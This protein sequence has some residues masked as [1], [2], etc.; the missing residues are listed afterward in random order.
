M[1]THLL[2]GKIQG[3]WEHSG[4]CVPRRVVGQGDVERAGPVWNGL[5]GASL[6]LSSV[7]SVSPGC[8]TLRR[9]RRP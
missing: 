2:A 3:P 5:V 8:I 7:C 6:S 9:A 4:V 1:A